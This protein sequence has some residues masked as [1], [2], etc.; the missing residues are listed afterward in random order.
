MLATLE[1]M[2]KLRME[3]V[4]LFLVVGK[5]MKESKKKQ[6]L[7]PYLDIGGIIEKKI[8]CFEREDWGRHVRPKTSPINEKLQCGYWFQAL[9]KFPSF[10]YWL[11]FGTYLGRR[12][13]IYSMVMFYHPSFPSPPKMLVYYSCCHDYPPT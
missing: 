11:V 3:T 5:Q 2:S 10:R 4:R 12:T 6:H 9:S 1:S 8:R 7:D 13:W